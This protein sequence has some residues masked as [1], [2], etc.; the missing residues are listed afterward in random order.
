[1]TTLE[2]RTETTQPTAAPEARPTRTLS[3][4]VDAYQNE[5]EFLLLADIPGV[6]ESGLEIRY[7]RGRIDLRGARP[8][9]TVYQRSF[10]VPGTIATD[11][12]TAEIQQGVLHLHLPKSEAAKPRQI[13]VV[14]R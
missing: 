12:I 13:Q 1:M 11:R 9:G 8:G 3:P 5:H 14:A 7:E 6:P 4:A 10:S 2:K